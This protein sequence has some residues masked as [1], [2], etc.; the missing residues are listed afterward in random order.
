MNLFKD[1][2]SHRD[3]NHEIELRRNPSNETDVSSLSPSNHVAEVETDSSSGSN[4]EQHRSGPSAYEKL[5][6]LTIHEKRQV[7]DFLSVCRGA[8]G[9]QSI[10]KNGPT[11]LL[12]KDLDTLYPE[13]N[14]SPD[15]LNY[16]INLLNKEE[17]KNGRCHWVYDIYFWK[18]LVENGFVKSWGEQARNIFGLDKLV[19][20]IQIGRFFSVIVIFMQQR[21]IYYYDPLKRN[22][23]YFQQMIVSYLENEWN[24]LKQCGLP[25][26]NFDVWKYGSNFS[27][28]KESLPV[29]DTGIFC[30]FFIGQILRNSMRAYHLDAAIVQKY[31]REVILHS[32]MI[33]DEYRRKHTR[34]EYQSSNA[35]K[36]HKKDIDRTITRNF[37]VFED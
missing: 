13:R 15:M 29:C 24:R 9:L 8:H 12:K 28:Q 35:I 34:E 4:N 18:T 33:T 2:S 31:G 22:G 11:V 5:S 37:E 36:R 10:A 20:P 17:I 14:M 21:F 30:S 3:L 25:F 27:Q 23:S 26:G 1:I 16:Y 7:T 6:P 19:I 32:I